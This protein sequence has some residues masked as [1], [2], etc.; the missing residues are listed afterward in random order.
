MHADRIGF[1]EFWA[2]VWRSRGELLRYLR[3]AERMR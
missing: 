1:G 3:W 2:F